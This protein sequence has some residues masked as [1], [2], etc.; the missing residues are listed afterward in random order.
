MAGLL[1]PRATKLL[2]DAIRQKHPDLPIHLHTQ[3]IDWFFLFVYKIN[4]YDFL[5]IQLELVLLII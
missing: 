4:S 3:L 1:K 5:V 2:V